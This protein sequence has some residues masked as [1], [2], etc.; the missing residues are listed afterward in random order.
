M[1]IEVCSN[2]C[3]VDFAFI[4]LESGILF[5]HNKTNLE[6]L[7]QTCWFILPKEKLKYVEN[8]NYEKI[9]FF[10][11]DEGFS[12]WKKHEFNFFEP[13]YYKI[14]L[15]EVEFYIKNE[16]VVNCDYTFEHEA[17]E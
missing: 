11:N 2:A 15:E 10:I 13:V 1:N 7:S 9:T 17:T 8:K 12:E 14:P 3:G 4:C 5:F 6:S 16:P